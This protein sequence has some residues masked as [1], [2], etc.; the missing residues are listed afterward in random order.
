[1]IRIN[2][3]PG[4]QRPK[5]KRAAVAAP[6]MQSILL[7]VGAIAGLLVLGGMYFLKA[8]ELKE[9]ESVLARQQA[10]KARLEKVKLEVDDMQSRMRVLELRSETIRTLQRNRV[11]GQQ[12][13]DALATTVNRSESVWLTL[14]SRKGNVLSIEGTASSV[15]AVANLITQLKRAGY[16]DKVEIR[17]SRQDDKQKAIQVFNFVI[18]AE[19]ALPAEK[20]AEDA[21]AEK[22]G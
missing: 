4:Q 9:A 16:F 7:G 21:A 2:L 3:L 8:G 6:G 12:L 5:A 22:K 19:F 14:L 18:T 15:S 11:G 1:M 20:P 17:E 10:E 13:L